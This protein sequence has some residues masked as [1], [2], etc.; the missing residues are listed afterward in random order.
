M[1]QKKT[2]G[3]ESEDLSKDSA[4]KWRKKA[5][6]R[7]S[8]IKCQRKRIGELE[9]SR[10]LWKTKYQSLKANPPTNLFE[11]TKAA[12]HQYSILLVLLVIK[13]QTYGTMSLRS[14][15]HC[16][17]ELCLVLGLSFRIPSASTIRWWICKSGYY[18]LK[19]VPHIPQNY[20]V[21]VD[22]SILIGGQKILLI[23]AVDEDK[24]KHEQS[25]Q[26]GSMKV[27][28]VESRPTWKGAG[29]ALIL[30]KLASHH[31][32]RYVVS[33]KGTNL[34]NAYQLSNYTHIPDCTHEFSNIL[35]GIYKGNFIFESFS[36]QSNDLRKRWFLSKDK[37]PYLPASQRGKMR[38]VNIFAVFKWAKKLI[39]TWSDLGAE[40]QKELGWLLE[41]KSLVNQL[42]MIEKSFGQIC[43]LL[44]NKGFSAAIKSQIDS[45]LWHLII[46][47]P[48]KEVLAFGQKVWLYLNELTALSM[49]L[50]REKLLC[51]S[52]IIETFFGKFKTKVVQNSPKKMTEFIYTIANYGSQLSEEQVKQALEKFRIC[53]I[54]SL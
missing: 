1:K 7:Q 32:I 3:N 27:L 12:R 10:N 28:W 43:H 8:I 30:D 36:K 19:S 5:L 39:D 24:L 46:E 50:G 14:C 25:L 34:I 13:W 29:I 16:L 31:K 37:A 38:F 44:K 2:R 15:R 53:D 6:Y 17:C 47:N 26:H 23:I 42:I 35:K 41:M 9:Q 22:E 20:V 11:G 49:A 21:Y 48:S 33:D 4:E 18:S 45:I 40:I 52:D 51:C 54:K